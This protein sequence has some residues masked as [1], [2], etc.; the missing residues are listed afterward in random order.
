MDDIT[1]IRTY[2]RRTLELAEQ[3]AGLTSP[4]AMV[5]AVVVKNGEII[6]EGF[7][8]YDG[9]YHAEVLALG[10]AEQDARGAT[11]YTS[12]E[13]CSHQGR[14]GPCAKAL[15]DAGVA[16][17]VTAMQDPNPDVNGDGLAM[18]RKAGIAVD[19][20]ILEEEARRLNEAFITYKLKGR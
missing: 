20:G 1:Y 17:V 5:G 7:Y 6:G 13:P 11:V 2:I 8:T 12:L 3:G 19:C 14:T 15:I 4:G 9:L 10:E 18:L 16:R